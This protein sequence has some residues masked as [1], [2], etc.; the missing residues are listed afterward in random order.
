MMPSLLAERERISLTSA[1]SSL[2][3]GG[4]VSP[5]SM[6]T[7]RKIPRPL[8]HLGSA[9]EWLVEGPKG[10]GKKAPMPEDAIVA[11][12]EVV[13]VACTSRNSLHW[14]SCSPIPLE[15]SSPLA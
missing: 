13:V 7:G 5:T 11:M 6:P 15:E 2:R 10:V 4:A 8:D 14:G 9:L 3:T 12:L 1:A